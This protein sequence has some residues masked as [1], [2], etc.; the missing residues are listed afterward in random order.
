V[1]YVDKA[2]NVRVPEPQEEEEEGEG[3][4]EGEDGEEITEDSEVMGSLQEF[5]ENDEEDAI[6]PIFEIQEVQKLE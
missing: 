1:L 5:S 6:K 3:E 4:G 2:K